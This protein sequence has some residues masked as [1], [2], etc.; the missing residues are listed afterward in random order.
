LA[1]GLWANHRELLLAAEGEEEED[2][3]HRAME[4]EAEAEEAAWQDMG[5]SRARWLKSQGLCSAELRRGWRC[6][7]VVV[8]VQRRLRGLWTVLQRRLRA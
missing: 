5:E 6:R 4:A 8:L 1:V 7:W 2:L 3:Q